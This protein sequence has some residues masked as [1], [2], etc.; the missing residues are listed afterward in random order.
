MTIRGA[1][2]WCEQRLSPTPSQGRGRGRTMGYRTMGVG[3]SPSQPWAHN[4][5]LA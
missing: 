2:H 3:P 1:S 4:P 5:E